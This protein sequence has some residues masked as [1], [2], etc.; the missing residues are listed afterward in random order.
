M[1]T[2]PVRFAGR[3]FSRLEGH[4]VREVTADGGRI[5]FHDHAGGHFA[6]PSLAYL[7]TRWAFGSGEL[8]G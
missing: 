7:A 3:V 2:Y 5:W 4:G 1:L 8:F 6:N